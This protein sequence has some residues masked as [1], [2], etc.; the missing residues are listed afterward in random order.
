MKNFLNPKWLLLINTVPILLLLF[1]G[2][3]EFS[4]IRSL[5][6][7]ESVYLWETFTIT[8]AVL[9]G[10]T[11]VYSVIQTLNKKK[12]SISYSIVSLVLYLVYLYL[13]YYKISDIFPSSI[14]NWMTSDNIHLYVSAALMPTLAHSVIVFSSFTDTQARK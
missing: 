7:E 12:L 3:H 8:I 4:I 2:W 6:E 13:Y 5:L 14:P 1:L 10:L 9:G 11:L